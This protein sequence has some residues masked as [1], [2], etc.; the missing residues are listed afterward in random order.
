MMTTAFSGR[1]AMPMWT[2]PDLHGIGMLYSIKCRTTPS[3]FPICKPCAVL[4]TSQ[5]VWLYERYD[6]MPTMVE[7]GSSTMVGCFAI[8]STQIF[9]LDFE[10]PW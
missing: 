5:P 2:A 8:L 9:G 3:S 7:F 1:M 6:L 10:L 4:I